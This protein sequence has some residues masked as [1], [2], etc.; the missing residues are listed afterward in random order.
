MESDIGTAVVTVSAVEPETA[1]EV[2]EMVVP[3]ASRAVADPVE[4]MLAT[5]EIEEP[6][7]AD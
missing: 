7:T 5:P 4:L 3:P 2:A 1:P 6:H